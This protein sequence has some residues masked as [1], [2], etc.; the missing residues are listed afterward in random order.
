[1]C[2]V[3]KHH[4]PVQDLLIKCH[5][6]QF[7]LCEVHSHKFKNLE[8]CFY[9]DIVY[10]ISFSSIVSTGLKISGRTP[11]SGHSSFLAKGYYYISIVKFEI[12][13]SE[14]SPSLCFAHDCF[15]SRWPFM[16]FYTFDEDCFRSLHCFWWDYHFRKINSS[17]P[18]AWKAC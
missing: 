7:L 4:I 10:Q 6:G 18:Q 11:S 13:F 15:G 14:A 16:T 1:M 8:I 3:L 9:R 12:K 17:N 5:A 2:K